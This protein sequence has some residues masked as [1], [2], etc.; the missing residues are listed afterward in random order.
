[1]IKLYLLL[2]QYTRTP[3]Q[4]SQS[5]LTRQAKIS[6]SVYEEFETSL[7]FQ[8]SKDYLQSLNAIAENDHDTDPLISA[9][10]MKSIS[11]LIPSTNIEC[12]PIM[13]E[14][15][16]RINR[17]PTLEK[18]LQVQLSNGNITMISRSNIV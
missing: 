6:Q 16:G 17:I 1:M 12:D 11:N 8:Y 7:A 3:K 10:R 15:L 13:E 4:E 5:Y 9:N 14:S 2:C 18:L